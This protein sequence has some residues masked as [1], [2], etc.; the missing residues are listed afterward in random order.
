MSSD[1]LCFPNRSRT[2]TSSAVDRHLFGEVRRDERDACI[3]AEHDITGEHRDFVDPDGHVDPTEGHVQDR[4]G[5]C[6]PAEVVDAWQLDEP[7]H[8]AD[9]P[10]DDRSGPCPRGDSGAEVV[11][12]HRAVLDLAEDI[13]NHD[14]AFDETFDDPRV[15]PVADRIAFGGPLLDHNGIEVGAMGQEV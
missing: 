9:P 2:A 11:A 15:L 8:V 1:N 12:D 14:V 10:V 4:G 13:R 7:G 6:S 5:V 3:G